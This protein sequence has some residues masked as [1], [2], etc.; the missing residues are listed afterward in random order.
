M[1]VNE[2]KFL[3][4]SGQ[5][6]TELLANLLKRN[7]MVE[8]KEKEV[9]QR[10]EQLKLNERTQSTYLTNMYD[11]I[12]EWEKRCAQRST[13]LVIREEELSEQEHA[14]EVKRSE[15]NQRCE[16]REKKVQE[17]EQEI[18]EKEV[19]WQKMEKRL[20]ENAAQ[21]QSIVQ[22]NVSMYLSPTH[23]LSCFLPLASLTFTNRRE[24]ICSKEGYVAQTQRI[25]LRAFTCKPYNTK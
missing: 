18:V 3:A 24:A 16:E 13:M 9:E 22:F 19:N 21:L 4:T 7:K 14:M 20:A 5:Q 6:F 15:L 17:R 12:K 23:A 8:E 1:G 11:D 25:T 2:D 10:M